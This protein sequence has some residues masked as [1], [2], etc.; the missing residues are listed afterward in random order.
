MIYI[1]TRAVKERNP[2]LDKSPTDV[3]ESSIKTL[4]RQNYG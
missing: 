3:E 1:I 2:G 4:K